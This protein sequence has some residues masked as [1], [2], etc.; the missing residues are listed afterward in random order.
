MRFLVLAGLV[1]GC[2][3]P[4]VSTVE[5]TPPDPVAVPVEPAAPAPEP[6]EDADGD[7]IVGAADRC[8]DAPETVNQHEDD[9]GCPDEAPAELPEG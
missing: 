7:G 2:A 5:V 6:A 1:G 8:P 4:V 3:G 9:D